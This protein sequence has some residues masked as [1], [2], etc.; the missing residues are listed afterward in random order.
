MA[1]VTTRLGRWFY[2]EHGRAGGPTIVLLHGLFFDRRMW[3][4]QAPALASVGKVI[5][6]DGPGHGRSE[7][8]PPFTLE[9][10]ADALAEAFDGLGI[11]R[12]I[13]VGL[14]W[15]A[16]VALRFALA[17]PARV[18][19]LAVLGGSAEIESRLDVAAHRVA[20]A[21]GRRLPLPELVA[22]RVLVPMI[23]S[24][25]T[26]ARDPALVDELVRVMRSQPR[27]GVARASQAVVGRAR[28]LT[29]AVSSIRVPSLV[30]CGEDDRTTPVALSRRLAASIP[31]A[32]L[33]IVRECGHMTATEQPAQVSD[34]LCAFARGVSQASA[35][36]N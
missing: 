25:R 14:S 17:H 30:L 36:V 34:A 19:G 33:E 13:V 28:R 11:E 8:P 26:M 24:P 27:E 9:D 6:F 7:L 15:G 21:L 20:V 4:H 5:V 22:R 35:T 23:L 2:E 32:Q 12:A 31:G 10:Q 3:E 1:F 29:F 16:M 18:S